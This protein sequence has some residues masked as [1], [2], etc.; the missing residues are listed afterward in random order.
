MPPLTTLL[1]LPSAPKYLRAR[2]NLRRVGA[3]PPVGPV[4]P[5]PLPLPLP[6]AC[7]RGMVVGRELALANCPDGA[8]ANRQG[9]GGGFEAKMAAGR[10][11]LAAAAAAADVACGYSF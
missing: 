11:G 2:T 6:S 8:V 4:A 5:L 3:S 1:P 7:G 10:W 9:K